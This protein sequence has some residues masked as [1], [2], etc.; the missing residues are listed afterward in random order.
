MSGTEN[1]IDRELQ[2]RILTCLR[3]MFPSSCNVFNDIEGTGESD[4]LIANLIYLEQ[5]GLIDSGVIFGIDGHASYSR[6]AINASGLDFLEADGGVAAILK[7]VTV[8]FHA[9][10]LREIAEKEIDKA[11]IP[12]EEK[13]SLKKSLAALSDKTLQAGASD[14]MRIGIEH[15]PNAVHWLQGLIG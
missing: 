9:D 8:K 7:T 10:T 2:L 3:R 4:Q 12:A 5:H 1:K 11:V 14:L 13:S 6:S 15:V